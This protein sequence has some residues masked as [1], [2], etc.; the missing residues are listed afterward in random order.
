MTRNLFS[1]RSNPFE[2]KK[3]PFPENYSGST[4]YDNYLLKILEENKDIKKSKEIKSKKKEITTMFR[5]KFG[6]DFL[7]VKPDSLILFEKL[8]VNVYSIL[9]VN[10]LLIFQSCK[11][12]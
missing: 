11:K 3:I 4:L 2:K 1:V 6:R 9:I 10:F 7:N 5:N 8:L 12:N